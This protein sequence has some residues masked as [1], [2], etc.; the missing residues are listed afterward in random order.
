QPVT[1]SAVQAALPAGSALIEFAV[2]TPRDLK[3]EKSKPPRY[4]A[5]VLASQGQPRWVE[6]GEA[7]KIDR[8]VDAWRK[9]L[10]DPKRTDVKRLAREVD[11]KVMRPVRSLL[12][13]TRRLLVAPDGLLNLI[14]YA[15][16]V[17]E[18]NQYLVEHYT[19]SYLTS[20]RDLLRYQTPQPN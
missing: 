1:L 19:I 16:L 8:A 13:E 9:A 18:R 20:G 14:P 7:A 12:G 5:Y 15:A 2:C 4:L 11:E 10:R 6:L 17:D 3:T